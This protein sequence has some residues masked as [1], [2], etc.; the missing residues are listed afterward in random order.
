M[1]TAVATR[2]LALCASLLTYTSIHAA[3]AEEICG[4]LDGSVILAQD[5]KNTFLG[6]IA[7]SSDRQS[8]FKE[9]GTYGNEF[10]S[11]SIWNEFSEFGNEFNSL[12]PFNEYSTSPPM[13]IK[14]RKIV[15]YLTTNKSINGGISPNL[16]KALCKDELG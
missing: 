13:M 4:V 15:G 3:G 12:S 16:L 9:Y 8:I 11:S 14:S 1:K 7:G 10:S 6:K 2:L 5:S